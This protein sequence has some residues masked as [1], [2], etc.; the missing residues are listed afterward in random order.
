MNL[1]KAF[2][3]VDRKILLSKLELYGVRGVVYQLTKLYLSNRLQYVRTD[4]KYSS[5]MGTVETGRRRRVVGHP[6]P[7]V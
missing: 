1:A 7:T 4:A 2:D 3:S 5:N 6:L